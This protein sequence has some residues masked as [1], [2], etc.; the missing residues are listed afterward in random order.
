MKIKDVPQ[1]PAY[2]VFHDA[3]DKGAMEVWGIDDLATAQQIAKIRNTHLEQGGNDDC[4]VWKAY[5][6]LPHVRVY[7]YHGK[8]EITQNV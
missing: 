5:N 1:H 6:K 3:F 7:A 4:G 2:L 8:K